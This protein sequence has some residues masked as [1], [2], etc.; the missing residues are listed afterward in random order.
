MTRPLY[1]AAIL[2][3]AIV[4]SA[5]GWAQLVAQTSGSPAAKTAPAR[6][7][8][9]VV[10]EDGGALSVEIQ[11]S[12]APVAPDTQAIVGPDRIVVDFPG[13]LPAADL[14]AL[15]VNLGPLKR[16][17]AGLFFSNPPITRVVLDLAEPQAYRIST[18]G[19]AIR[20]TLNGAQL[21]VA[22]AE[23]STKSPA[24]RAAL[25][26]A[27]IQNPTAGSAAGSSAGSMSGSMPVAKLNSASLTTVARIAPAQVAAVSTRQAQIAVA[28]SPVLSP[29]EP[30]PSAP[31]D[32]ALRPKPLLS[33]V[34]ANGLLHIR[35]DR[36]TLAQVLFE[37]QRETQADIAIP[38]GAEQEEVAADIGPAPARDV[39]GA[40]LN[41]SHYNFIF[42]GDEA[43]LERV[44]LT[45]REPN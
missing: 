45:R 34:Y 16:V 29:M 11:T 6:I 26:P 22:K 21:S 31:I 36:A 32:E 38:A 7:E 9:V 37:V 3:A 28:R 30:A 1:L 25:I 17:R 41:G 10:H 27:R 4:L 33:V 18:A 42:V 24:N 39:L 8:H 13:A 40:L 15:Q 14:R 43:R 35:V 20:V 5:P 2:S 12:G 44:I 23:S 19:N